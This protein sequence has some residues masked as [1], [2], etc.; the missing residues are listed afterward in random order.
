[1]FGGAALITGYFG[2]VVG[3]VVGAW[4]GAQLDLPVLSPILGIVLGLAPVAWIGP[5][6]LQ[7]LARRS[8][9]WSFT[10]DATGLTVGFERQGATALIPSRAASLLAIMPPDPWPAAAKGDHTGFRMDW[11]DIKDVTF[12]GLTLDLHLSAERR[13]A[14]Y[15]RGPDHAAIEA[16]LE[17]I[18]QRVD[19]PS[20]GADDAQ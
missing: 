17:A 14:L 13:M 10:G 3:S 6:A 15:M 4:T 5:Q 2:F 11:S 18:R 8:V 16:V 9:V 19:T 1:M 12:E 7:D 20:D